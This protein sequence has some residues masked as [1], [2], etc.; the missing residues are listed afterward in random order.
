MSAGTR[1]YAARLFLA[2]DVF[3][4]ESPS[5]GSEVRSALHIGELCGY[6]SIAHGKNVN[7]P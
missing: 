7:A 2:Q 4:N 3:P 5:F 1:R 6:F